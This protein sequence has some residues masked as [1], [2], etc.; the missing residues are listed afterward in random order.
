MASDLN[1]L[2]EA[3]KNKEVREALEDFFMIA[4]SMQEQ[5][6]LMKAN[7]ESL[8]KQGLP[9]CSEKC[10]IF[11]GKRRMIIAGGPSVDDD[12][13]AIKKYRKKVVIL[14]VG[15]IVKKLLENGIIPYKLD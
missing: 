12:I 2:L 5:K 10:R 6:M 11:T 1:L 8:Q 4:A 14:D 9:E 15:R 7:F 3:Q 13:D